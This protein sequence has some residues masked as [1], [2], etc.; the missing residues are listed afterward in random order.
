MSTL[1][2]TG[3]ICRSIICWIIVLV[4]GTSSFYSCKNANTKLIVFYDKE[5]ESMKAIA[6]KENKF[7]C[8]VLSR[9]DC[10]MCQ[11]YIQHFGELYND[12]A[13]QVIFN[14]VDVSLPENWWYQHWLGTGASPTTCVFSAEGELKAVVEGTKR[15]AIECIKSTVTDHARCSPYFYR[16]R[17][18]A[19]RDVMQ[20]LNVLLNCKLNLD[21]GRP[22][23]NEINVALAQSGHPYAIYLKAISQAEKGQPEEAAYWAGEFLSMVNSNNYDSRVYANTLRQIK[24]IIHPN[25][26]PAD[27][28]VLLVTG[29]LS[30][31]H[32]KLNQPRPFT[33]TLTNTGQSPLQVHDVR[34]SCSCVKIKGERQLELQPGESQKMEFIFTADVKGNVIREI[35]FFSNGINLMETIKIRARVS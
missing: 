9:P 8:V 28:G 27:E 26:N 16:T 30:L 31:G 11:H 21:K 18:H 7:F 33:L 10:P 34:L 15:N 1:F 35:T 32:S 22:I 24:T 3:K 5:L 20:V 14:I 17:F 6:K 25:Y 19:N 23:C 29:E 12:I 4:V 2:H 13:E